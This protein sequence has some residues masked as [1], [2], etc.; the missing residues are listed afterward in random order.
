MQLNATTGRL[1]RAKALFAGLS[2]AGCCVAAAPAADDSGSLS[3]ANQFPAYTAPSEK[4]AQ[5]FDLPG[6][7]QKVMVKEGDKVKAGQLIAQQ[8]IDADEAKLKSLELIAHSD[9]EIRAQEA[10]QQKDEVDLKR[11]TELR[12]KNAISPS[13]F[14]E[15]QLAVAI[16][17]LKVEKGKE[18]KL[19]A[20][21][22]VAEQ[23]ARIEEKKL[24]ARIDGL[25]SEITTH[26]GELANADTQHA[27]ITIVKNDLLYVE[28]DLPA[29]VVKKL[30][31]WPTA[32]PL[33]VQYIDDTDKNAWHD[34]KI[35]FIKPEADPKAN[36]EHV[37]LEMANPEGRSAGLQVVVK[38]PA[39]LVPQAGVTAANV[40]P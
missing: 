38:L 39:E 11:K 22:D 19:K 12:A 13:E 37:Q 25:V 14:D 18:D 9:L 6:V 21:Y 40:N 10:Q 23:K 35:H 31:A 5:N 3:P 2:I 20:S 28:V 1:S 36:T 8:D 30:K 16:D 7:V 15:A 34:A 4:R 33:Q 27:T 17:K 32:K 26:E 24:Y 29:D